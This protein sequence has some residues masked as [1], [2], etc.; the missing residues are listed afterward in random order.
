MRFFEGDRVVFCEKSAKYFGHA[1]E[2]FVVTS[3][4][5]EGIGW[6]QIKVGGFSNWFDPAHFVAAE[7]FPQK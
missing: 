7:K 1:G 3:V 5:A 4:W 6:E 2:V